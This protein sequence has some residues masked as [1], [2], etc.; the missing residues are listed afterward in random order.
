M[1]IISFDTGTGIAEINNQ[2]AFNCY[3]NP[4]KESSVV[5][6]D[7]PKTETL[8]LEVMDQQGR[9]VLELFEENLSAGK[10]KFQLRDLQLSS[11]AYIWRLS[12][13]ESEYLS[14]FIY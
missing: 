6:I 8:K 11:G 2:W 7:L 1:K 5:T 3:P 14:P 10:H 13:G 4:I 12:N 9:I